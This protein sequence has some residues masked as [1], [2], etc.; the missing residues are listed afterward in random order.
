MF[1]KNLET[2]HA[3]NISDAMELLF[4]GDT[5]RII[6]RTPKNDESTRS[7]CIFIITL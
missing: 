2:H 6:C 7:H 1:L 4:L 3:K 5:N